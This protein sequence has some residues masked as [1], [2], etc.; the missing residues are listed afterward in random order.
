MSWNMGQTDLGSQEVQIA[1]DLR[2]RVS[3]RERRYIT[4][5]YDRQVTGNLQ[6]E[7]ETL[8]SWAQTYPRDPDAPGITSGWVA[9]GTGNYERGIRAAMQARRIDPTIPYPYQT[10]AEHSMYLE[11]YQQS[12]AILA[13][14]A[15]HKLELPDLTGTRYM[16]AFLQ[17]DVA[18]ME[19]EVARAH[20]EHFENEMNHYQALYRAQAGR[21][22]EARD[23]W[24]QAI[25]LTKLAGHPESAAIMT[26]AEAV[27][28]AH[29]G[30]QAAARERA[31]EAL[32]LGKGRDVVYAAAFALA[33]SGDIS[34]SQKLAA[35]LANRFPEDTPVQFEY[36]PILQ[37][38][39]ALAKQSPGG[40]LARLQHSVPYDLAIP[41]TA[42]FAKFGGMYTVYVRGQ[43]YLAAGRPQDAVIE[44]DKILKHPAI[45][46][47]D[48]IGG[49]VHLQL[50]RAYAAA[51]DKSKAKD[52]YNQF[53]TAWKNADA[54]LPVFQQA[55][56]EFARL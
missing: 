14:A 49:F 30:N 48:P 13:E 28:E 54:D 45:I 19:R 35:D 34:A 7:L 16:L 47:F 41:G 3:D 22:R 6:K 8:E 25:A 20:D 26:A 5:L 2:N 39:Y 1:Y 56:A 27:C 32:A 24:D 46:Q 23:L 4:M 51:G 52:A 38:L 50:G 44:F 11:R 42:F 53:L 29:L 18:G 12:S 36:L 40:A 43:A 33:L 9:F 55:K 37:G 21:M 15:A 10:G 17:H 31:R